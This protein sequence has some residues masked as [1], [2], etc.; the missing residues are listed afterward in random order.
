MSVTTT[1][2]SSPAISWSRPGRSP[3]T[4]TSCRSSSRSSSWE[5]PSRRRTLSSASTTRS[6]I[7]AH[8]IEA[9]PPTDGMLPAVPDP[10][11]PVLVGV[12]TALDDAEAAELMVRAATAAGVDAGAP[13]L[14]RAVQQVAVPRGTWSYTDPARIVAD[15]IGAPAARTVLVDLGIPQ[16]TLVNQ[17]L[18]AIASGELEVALVVGGEA[19]A[20]AAR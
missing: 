16:Q 5:M 19:R 6:A 12:G 10:R 1:S 13:D 15:R 8:A 20:R 7:A 14:L 9:H 3:A 2:G 11:S 17:A 18:A 4:P